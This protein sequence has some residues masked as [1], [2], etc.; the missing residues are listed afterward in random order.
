MVYPQTSLQKD[1]SFTKAILPTKQEV[2]ITETIQPKKI[3]YHQENLEPIES[4]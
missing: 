1:M 2:S 4:F 3:F